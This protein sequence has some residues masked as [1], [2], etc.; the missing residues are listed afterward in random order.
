MYYILRTS[1]WIMSLTFQKTM[2]CCRWRF[3][4]PSLRIRVSKNLLKTVA[5]CLVSNFQVPWS[6]P[7]YFSQSFLPVLKVRQ[8]RKQIMLSWILP[9]NER[10]IST[11]KITTSRLVQKRVYLLLLTFNLEKSEDKS[12]QMVRG[13]FLPKS[14][15]TKS[16]F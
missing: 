7:W 8:S 2:L 14:L 6:L 15:F 4:G 9:K 16:I 13:S 11:S 1:S 5:E 10:W 12:V 3:W